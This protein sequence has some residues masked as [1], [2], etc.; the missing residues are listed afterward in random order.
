MKTKTI[1]LQKE[2]EEYIRKQIA[3]DLT[4]L[5]DTNDYDYPEIQ[6][7]L[8]NNNLYKFDKKFFLDCNAEQKK[9][10][11]IGESLFKKLRK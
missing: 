7:D 6:E 11:K 4:S 5:A 8:W 3:V 10:L 9:D 1:K 2:E